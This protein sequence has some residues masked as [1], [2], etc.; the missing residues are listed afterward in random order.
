[1]LRA[2]LMITALASGGGAA[3]MVS[4]TR[5]AVPEVQA[6]MVAPTPPVNMEEILVAAHDLP[7]GAK[8]LPT[9]LVWKTWPAEAV[10]ASFVLRSAKP[11]APAELAGS[12]L[13]DQ[14][15][16]GLPLAAADVAPA[17]SNLLS[18]VLTPG[19]RAVSIPISVEQTAG[20]FVLPDDRVD[21]MLTRACSTG[22]CAGAMDARTI[23]RNVRVLAIDQSGAEPNTGTSLIGKT[24][25]L[26]LSPDQAETLVG[27]QATGALSLVLRSAADHEQATE[28]VT[29]PAAAVA[30]KMVVRERRG[31]VSEEVTLR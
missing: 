15:A 31:N 1:M 14:V 6:A 20:G 29:A 12:V 27:A 3:W 30:E 2:L 4:Q 9:D 7:R 10:N 13:R 18:A 23:L 28:S 24:A 25:T 26:E 17:G 16:A 19:M 5:T 21:I 22:S 8:L 11:E